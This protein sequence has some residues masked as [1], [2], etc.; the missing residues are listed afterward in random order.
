VDSI[1]IVAGSAIGARFVAF[2]SAAG[3]ELTGNKFCKWLV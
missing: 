1:S 2:P 3:T